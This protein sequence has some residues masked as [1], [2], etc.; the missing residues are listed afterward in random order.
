MAYCT[1]DEVI[2]LTGTSL[3]AVSVLPEII[4]QADREIDAQLS[5]AGLSSPGSNDILKAAALNLCVAGV[6]TRLKSDGTMASKKI[7]SLSISY[8]DLPK[9][10]EEHRKKAKELIKAYIL[11]QETKRKWYFHKVN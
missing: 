2:A 9:S 7:G 5:L 4:A 6:M 10:I 1:T 11:T 8:A 3:S